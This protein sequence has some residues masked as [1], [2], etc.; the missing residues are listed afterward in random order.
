MDR[1]LNLVNIGYLGTGPLCIA[2]ISGI[3]TW[4]YH[5]DIISYTSQSKI[6]LSAVYALAGLGVGMWVFIA[7]GL[8]APAAA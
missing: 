5:D 7:L 3:L 8:P 1:L 6:T 4:V 2:A